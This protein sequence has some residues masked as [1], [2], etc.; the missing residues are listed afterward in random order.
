M[1]TGARMKQKEAKIAI[2]T[3]G[4]KANKEKTQLTDF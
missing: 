3:E 1:N 4:N 2:G